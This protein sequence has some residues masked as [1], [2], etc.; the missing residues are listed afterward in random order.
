[1]LLSPAHR[2]DPQANVLHLMCVFCLFLL[3]KH[4]QNVFAIINVI[5]FHSGG[6]DGS[7][8]LVTSEPITSITAMVFP[9]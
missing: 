9:P 6:G 8:M 5:L 4:T 1:M 2:N 7:F 3:H